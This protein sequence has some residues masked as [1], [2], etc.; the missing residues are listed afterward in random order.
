LVSPTGG[1]IRKKYINRYFYRNQTSAQLKFGDVTIYHTTD[2]AAAL[3]IRQEVFIM[4][5]QLLNVGIKFWVPHNQVMYIR[6]TESAPVK[7]RIAEMRRTGLLHDATCGK[8]TRTLIILVTGHGI[9]LPI[10]P[11]TMENRYEELF[12]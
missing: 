3:T 1:V 9:I 12:K 4:K 8:K 6:A 2:G 5:K 10:Q 7:R 11:E